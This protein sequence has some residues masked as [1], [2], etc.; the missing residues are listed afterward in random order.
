MQ[1]PDC[2]PPLAPTLDQQFDALKKGLGRAVPW[3]DQGRLELDL[4]WKA[5]REDLRFDAQCEDARGNW[6]WELIRAAGADDCFRP[7]LLALLRELTDQPSGAQLC[8]LAH[9][10]AL[11]GDRDFREALYQIVAEKRDPDW[12][13]L[14]EEEIIRLDGGPAFLFAAQVRGAQLKERD[15]DWDDGLLVDQAGEHLGEDCVKAL[16]ESATDDDVRRFYRAWGQSENRISPKSGES[17]ADKMRQIPVAQIIAAAE[18]DGNIF[19]HFRGWGRHANPDDLETV[20]QKLSQAQHARAI[21]RLLRVFSNR[22]FPRIVPELFQFCRHAE[23]EV[24]RWAYLA[25]AKNAHPLV[26]EFAVA[27]L[28]RGFPEID[29]VELFVKNYC[30]GDERRILEAVELPQDSWQLHGLMMDVL[31]ILESNSQANGVQLGSIA[32]RFTPCAMCRGRAVEILK[33]RR[34]APPWLLEEC[35]FDADLHTREMVR[36]REN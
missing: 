19:P 28:R 13:W 16:L 29:A 36:S 4:L 5:C 31:K 21:V 23:E 14:G 32:Y 10:Y 24:R 8:E 9:R 25:L 30:P 20:F 11:S 17:Y 33:E 15:W 35:R 7:A 6:L 18:S 12:R 26:R 2:S 3:A 34:I 1:F 22:E 27:E